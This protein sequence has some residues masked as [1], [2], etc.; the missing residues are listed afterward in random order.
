MGKS[1]TGS[2]K[3][4]RRAA[5]SARAAR[6]AAVKDTLTTLCSQGKDFRTKTCEFTYEGDYA[7][8]ETCMKKQFEQFCKTHV[9]PNEETVLV[10]RYVLTL[11]DDR[12]HL[13]RHNVAITY[14]ATRDEHT[15][16]H[17]LP[18]P[19]LSSPALPAGPVTPHPTTLSRPPSCLAVNRRYTPCQNNPNRERHHFYAR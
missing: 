16:V 18:S 12:A 15:G 13:G 17:P 10:A 19:P 11:G 1:I 3:A 2:S 8:S 14:G 5:N 7:V 9:T 4:A 6:R